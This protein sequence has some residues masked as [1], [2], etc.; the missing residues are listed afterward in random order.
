MRAFPS[1]EALVAA[2]WRRLARSIEG[3]RVSRT[4]VRVTSLGRRHRQAPNHNPSRQ[5]LADG[6][7]VVRRDK[8]STRGRVK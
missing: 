2:Y 8:T 7:A 6:K 5:R 3:P 1:E 4:V